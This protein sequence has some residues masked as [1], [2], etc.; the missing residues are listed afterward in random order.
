MLKSLKIQRFRLLEDFE[1]S[2]LGRVNLM[3]GKNN[4]GKST[5][6]DALRI[7][8]KRGSMQLLEEMLAEH[9]ENIAD[10]R[11][12]D[13]TPAGTDSP[14]RNFFWG[15]EF[16]LGSDLPIYIGSVDRSE[17]VSIGYTHFVEETE[18]VTEGNEVVQLRKRRIVSEGEAI[19]S[20]HVLQ[21]L[22]IA[23]DYAASRIV[24]FPSAEFPRGLRGRPSPA[25]PR[26]IP[27][28]Y[29]P[30]QFLPEE[31]LAEL[32]DRIA[33]RTESA[34]VISALRVV[35]PDVDGIAFVK[36]ESGKYK[37]RTAL[38]KMKGQERPISLGSMGDGMLRVLQLVLTMFSAARGF[39]LV[40]EFE[41][42]LHYSIQA[43][44]WELVFEMAKR[45]DIQ[46]FAATHSW[47][48][49]EAF[50]AAAS[51]SDE[52]GVLFRIG[53]SVRTS[54]RGRV[55]ATVFDEQSLQA[56]TQN[57]VEVR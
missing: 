4:C 10:R 47:D 57:D 20:Q 13:S 7:L 34:V 54:D 50:K 38:V 17:F 19:E 29:I 53:K 46:V 40:D 45:L 6:L 16:P 9:D 14:Y 8:A 56:I 18:E 28:S 21:G 52:E 23:T 44:V 48:C 3:V 11:S 55:I 35:D 5:V 2:S 43:R 36:K 27:V 33:L 49:I 12:T 42:G 25:G 51:R 41:N 30:T 31:Q 22:V 37:E 26:D 24:T 39:F 15:R 32:W 1:V